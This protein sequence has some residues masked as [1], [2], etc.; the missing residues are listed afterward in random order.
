MKDKIKRNIGSIILGLVITVVCAF[1]LC[2]NIKS[3]D[4]FKASFIDVLTVLFGAV[5]TFFMT[6]RIN[7]RRRR[8]ECIEH[9]IMEIESFVSNE[10]NFQIEKRTLVRQSSCANRIK[11]LKDSSFSEIKKDIEFIHR[12]YEEIRDLYS[13]HCKSDADL[14]SVQVD[15]DKH[16]SN[17]VDKCNKIRI[18]LY[19]YVN[20]S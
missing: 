12:N 18:S 17:I 10:E 3:S 1:L 4:F 7:D 15:I 9:I 2:E 11:Y 8:N 6:Q 19:G 16:R 20:N 13:N 5:I 14:K